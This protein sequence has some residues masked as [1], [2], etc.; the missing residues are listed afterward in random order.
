MREEDLSVR[1]TFSLILIY[2]DDEQRK[3]VS[4][5]SSD[6]FHRAHS[7]AFRMTDACSCQQS[8]TKQN[9]KSSIHFNDIFV[10]YESSKRERYYNC[11]T[12]Y[13][14]HINAVTHSPSVRSWKTAQVPIRS[15]LKS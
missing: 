12:V 14:S 4:S 2:P 10:L 9:T 11:S 13:P 5:G 1:L 6:D 3:T 7:F 8:T 15:N